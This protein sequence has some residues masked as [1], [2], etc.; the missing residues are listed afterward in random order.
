MIMR[1]ILLILLLLPVNMFVQENITSDSDVDRCLNDTIRDDV[2]II[3]EQ[4]PKLI[5]GESITS[6]F[7]SRSFIVDSCCLFKACISFVVET[8]STITDK[9][10]NVSTVNCKQKGLIYS[11]A[12]IE[13]VRLKID[14]IL[15]NM[16]E[17]VP[18][19]I[20]N[21]SVAVM[22]SIPIHVDCFIR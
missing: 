5:N 7:N 16:P 9:M 22:I 15:S 13:S 1:Y 6:Y 4:M 20:N 12:E 10:I 11:G 3:A 8:D 21:K 18:G 2:Y 19:R 17:L 14:S